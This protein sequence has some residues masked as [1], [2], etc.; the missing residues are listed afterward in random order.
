MNLLILLAFCLHG[1][2]RGVRRGGDGGESGDDMSYHIWKNQTTQN[3]RYMQESE[4]EFLW[5]YIIYYAKMTTTQIEPNI[6]NWYV[7]GWLAMWWIGVLKCK[8]YRTEI[9]ILKSSPRPKLY[10]R[11]S[12]QEKFKKKFIALSNVH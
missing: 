7:E 5:S 11:S 10:F 3:R 9:W 8:T 6:S 2:N 12:K 1:E 4:N